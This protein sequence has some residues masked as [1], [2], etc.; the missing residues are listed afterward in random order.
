M[1]CKI[2]EN[3]YSISSDNG[4]G[5]TYRLLT[6]VSDNELDLAK[7]AII[8]LKLK[9]YAV[10]ADAFNIYGDAV[11]DMNGVYIDKNKLD[12]EPY[13]FDKFH[14]VLL[15]MKEE[16]EKQEEIDEIDKD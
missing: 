11:P 16:L 9:E 13:L 4:D 1:I 15:V 8:F 10:V 7:L 14:N 3:E 5:K 12:S 2:K 6:N